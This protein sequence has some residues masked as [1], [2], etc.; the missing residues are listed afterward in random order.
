MAQQL[1]APSAP[2]KVQSLIPSNHM[3]AHRHL[4]DAMLTSGVSDDSY[5]VLI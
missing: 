4:W 2:P 5:S 3:V 1:R